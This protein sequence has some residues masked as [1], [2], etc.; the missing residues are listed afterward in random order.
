MAAPGGAGAPGLYS[1]AGASGTVHYGVAGQS[2]AAAAQPAGLRILMPS[3][4]VQQLGWASPTG[5]QQQQQH[6]QAM[7]AAGGVAGVPVAIPSPQPLQASFSMPSMAAP[8]PGLAASMSALPAQ[9]PY[10]QPPQPGQLVPL[11]FSPIEG[12][13]PAVNFHVVSVLQLLIG[14]TPTKIY[15]CAATGSIFASVRTLAT[16]Q[17]GS[18]K[19]GARVVLTASNTL[20]YTQPYDLVAIK[21]ESKQVVSVHQQRLR[22]GGHGDNSLL[23][24]ALC[25]FFADTA[26]RDKVVRLRECW[27]D[28]THLYAVMDYL[29]SDLFTRVVSERPVPHL[30]EGEPRCCCVVVLNCA[31]QCIG[32]YPPRRTYAY[33]LGFRMVNLFAGLALKFATDIAMA[34]HEVHAAGWCH[35]DVSPE[36]VMVAK[37]ASGTACASERALLIDFGTAARMTPASAVATAATGL[38]TPPAAALSPARSESSGSGTPSTGWLSAMAAMMRH[39]STATSTSSAA[40]T[41]SAASP[42]AAASDASPAAAANVACSAAGGAAGV[43]AGGSAVAPS[44]IGGWLALPPPPTGGSFCKPGYCCPY[45]FWHQ[46]YWGVAFDLWSLAC[47]I[48]FMVEGRHLYKLP[49]PALDATFAMMY[50]AEAGSNSNGNSAAGD[51]SFVVRTGSSGTVQVGPAAAFRSANKSGSSASSGVSGGAGSMPSAQPFARYLDD[52][53]RARLLRGVPPLS[54]ELCDLLSRTLRIR[55]QFRPLSVATFLQ[56]PWFHMNTRPP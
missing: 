6:Q 19:L 47:T 53:N 23:D 14:G 20:E 46:P 13:L 8:S 35:R 16:T 7:W 30:S 5:A 3:A 2:S 15:Y 10:Q 56:H 42:A 27:H 38:I 29:E 1:P 17:A 26:A 4:P 41:V 25:M 49:Q 31:H 52:I 55:P 44:A 50:A 12:L 9:Q 28:D 37:A 45:Y 36:N 43:A 34:L 32:L 22:A 33:P 11:S 40:S 21:K 24:K 39:S 48:F 51:G 54:S 18:V